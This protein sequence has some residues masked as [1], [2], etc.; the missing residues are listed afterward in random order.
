MNLQNWSTQIIILTLPKFIPSLL[1]SVFTL[2]LH[3][4]YPHFYGIATS[5]TDFWYFFSMTD[6]HKPFYSEANSEFD[7][8]G[9]LLAFFILLYICELVAITGHGLIIL[10]SKSFFCLCLPFQSFYKIVTLLYYRCKH[11]IY[12]SSSKYRG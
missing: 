10:A 1:L 3:S 8:R 4:I 11:P 7:Q 5:S 12:F 6:G 2:D 9:D